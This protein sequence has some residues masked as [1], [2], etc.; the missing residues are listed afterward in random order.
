MSVASYVSHS[1]KCLSP[2]SGPIGL[3]F[4]VA[5][6]VGVKLFNADF[7]ALTQ[8]IERTNDKIAL[9]PKH[10]YPDKADLDDDF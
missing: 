6:L 3:V 5:T 4:E 8:H 7:E 2:N 1:G 9:L 10:I